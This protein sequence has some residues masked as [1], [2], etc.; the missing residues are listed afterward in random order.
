MYDKRAARRSRRA[1][2]SSAQLQL[3]LEASLTPD[4]FAK[5]IEAV[6]CLVPIEKSRHPLVCLFREAGFHSEKLQ[7]RFI[8]KAMGFLYD[9][10]PRR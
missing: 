5:A 10:E 3:Q 4:A 7:R 9:Y 1:Q 2:A 8:T 6:D